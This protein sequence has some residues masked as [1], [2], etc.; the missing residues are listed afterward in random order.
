MCVYVCAHSEQEQCVNES[1]GVPWVLS[2]HS[3][4]HASLS[5][6]EPLALSLQWAIIFESQPVPATGTL[7]CR[8]THTRAHIFTH[9]HTIHLHCLIIHNTHKSTHI[10]MCAFTFYGV[11]ECL[12]SLIIAVYFRTLYL[13]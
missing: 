7:I 11:P 13:K 10:Q 3:P 12:S 1:L 5:Q 2:P 9:T 8:R 6:M 4:P